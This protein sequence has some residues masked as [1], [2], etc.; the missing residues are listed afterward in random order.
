MKYRSHLGRAIS[1]YIAMTDRF[2]EVC[3]FIT[4]YNISSSSCTSLLSEYLYETG[5]YHNGSI[6]KS[7]FYYMCSIFLRFVKEGKR[8]GIFHLNADGSNGVKLPHDQT[9]LEEESYIVLEPGAYNG[10]L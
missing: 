8:W 2:Q 4:T 6:T 9:T 1:I 7:T 3:S 5:V 10:E